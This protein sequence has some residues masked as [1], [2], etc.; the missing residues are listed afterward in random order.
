M[1]K[2][3]GVPFL[4]RV[5]MDPSLSRAGEAGM[6]VSFDPLDGACCDSLLAARMV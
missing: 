3:L 5:P 4:G 6:A 1:A 2:A